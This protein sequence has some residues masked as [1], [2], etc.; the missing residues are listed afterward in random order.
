MAKTLKLLLTESVESLGIV[1]D[2]VS[3]RTGYARN[4]LLPRNMATTPTDELVKSLASK[5]AEAEREVAL[6]RKH[7]EELVTKLQGVEIELV[8][9]CNDQG[10][11][12]GGI[13]QQELS[14]ILGEKGYGVKPRDIR[15]TEAIK[16]VGSYEVH[17]KLA[18]D[19]EANVKLVVKP[20][21]ELELDRDA[22]RQGD[23]AKKAEAGK[24]AAE[25]E[26]PVAGAEG[27]PKG[28]ER[29]GDRGERGGDRGGDRP[30]RRDREDRGDRAEKRR[31]SF[32]DRIANDK[33]EGKGTFGV[34][35]DPNAEAAPSAGPK[36]AGEKKPA[37][38]SDKGGDKKGE[39]KGKSKKE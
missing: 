24:E 22:H 20:D 23:K 29:G 6:Q 31:D 37:K 26:A 11:L 21:R 34:R 2:V 32:M 4:F 30:Q 12:Y 10:H 15:L 25:G 36:D 1:G 18:S 13:T 5:R 38:K 27:A 35:K 16:R 9:G 14:T 8:K 7:R 17:I 19:L 28:G 3:V 39:K 33:G